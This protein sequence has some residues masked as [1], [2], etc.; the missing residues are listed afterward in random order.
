MPD[1]QPEE[2]TLD[3]VWA[4]VPRGG[5]GLV[6]RLVLENIG[7]NVFRLH[8]KPSLVAL[9]LNEAPLD[10]RWIVMMEGRQPDYVDV[11]PGARAA[12]TVLWAGWSGPSASGHFRVRCCEGFTVDVESQGFQQPG[13]QGRAR[14]LSSSWWQLF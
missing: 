11:A 12:A 5:E 9:G 8:H 3:L 14:N 4:P 10:A 6:G 13:S 1:P 2:F 7:E